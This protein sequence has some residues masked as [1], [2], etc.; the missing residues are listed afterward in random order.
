M[1]KVG[2]VIE[3]VQYSTVT[4]VPTEEL[5]GAVTFTAEPNTDSSLYVTWNHPLTT[6]PLL[7]RYEVKVQPV[8]SGPSVSYFPPPGALTI[9]GG[10]LPGNLYRVSVV[11]MSSLGRGQESEAIL[12][13]TFG[14]RKLT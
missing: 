6:H 13:R 9:A 12:T 5:P 11:A 1:N 7:L 3:Y 14:N 2:V 8:D 10:L 4:C